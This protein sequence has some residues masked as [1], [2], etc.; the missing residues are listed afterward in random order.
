M[1]K[2]YTI[3]ACLVFS[4]FIAG[5][6]LAAGT[7][8]DSA[9][10]TIADGSTAAGDLTGIKLSPNVSLYYI[11]NADGSHF[12]I[13]SFNSKGDKAYGVSSF[14]NGVYMKEA[15]TLDTSITAADD[16]F[17]DWAQMGSGS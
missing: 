8:L 16:T 5:T 6:A 1:K 14:G 4:L 3:F 2:T 17:S 15:S 7:T 13:D 12:A 9:E 10:D 11:P